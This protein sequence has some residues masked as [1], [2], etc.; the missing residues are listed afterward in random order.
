M[1]APGLHVLQQAAGINVVVYYSAVLLKAEGFDDRGV[2]LS[3]SLW[4]DT[5]IFLP[6]DRLYTFIIK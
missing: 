6:R 4:W 5:K 1:P 3:G 2:P